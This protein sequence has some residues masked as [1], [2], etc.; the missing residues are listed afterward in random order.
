MLGS[1]SAPAAVQNCGGLLHYTPGVVSSLRKLIS[2]AGSEL[3]LNL[4]I[5]PSGVTYASAV[6]YGSDPSLVDPI[7]WIN[8]E[9]AKGRTVVSSAP[10]LSVGSTGVQDMLNLALASINRS[11][12]AQASILAALAGPSSSP[13]TTNL[14]PVSDGVI[15]GLSP[16]LAP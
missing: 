13:S 12:P 16:V 6:L 1:A 15:M 10:G 2:Q 9:I 7:V 5:G 14:V 8:A 11:S 4:Y 3:R